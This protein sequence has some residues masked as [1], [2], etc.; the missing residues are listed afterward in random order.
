MYLKNDETSETEKTKKERAKEELANIGYSETV[1]DHWL[2]P[3]NLGQM[4]NYNGF[5]GKISSSCGD[6]IWIW[7]KVEK[8][9]VKKATFMSDICIGA[10]S[11]GSI[12]TEMI[13]GKD[14]AR[15]LAIS[16][17]D[18]LT[19]LGGLPK[20]Y[21]HCAGLAANALKYAIAD[22]NAYEAAPWKKFYEQKK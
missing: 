3:R 12:L 9:I 20:K 14:I 5:S 21:E 7:I 19:A 1:I 16:A 15:I 18:I 13:K 2:N 17:D 11:A 10:V 6:S 4:Q 8:R 22:Y